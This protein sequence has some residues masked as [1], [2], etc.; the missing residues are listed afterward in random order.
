[1][2]LSRRHRQYSGY[3]K[4]GLSICAALL[5]ISGGCSRN[6]GPVSP[7]VNA[8][9]TG[10]DSPLAEAPAPTQAPTKV[11]A[12]ATRIVWEKTFEAALAKAKSSGKPVM[13]D[14]YAVWCG[15]CKMLDAETYTA[16]PVIQEAANF[17]NVKVDGEKRPDLMQRYKLNGFPTVVLADSTGKAI[18]IMPGFA[19]A[20]SFVEFMRSGLSKHVG[21]TVTT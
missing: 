20:D 9:N 8:G 2:L 12:K 18:E 7:Q 6:V 13:I 4:T 21:A 10:T 15:P 14:F 5:V 19:P 3:S 1:M 11:P 17:I 16:Q